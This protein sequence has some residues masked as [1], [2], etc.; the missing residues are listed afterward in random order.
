VVFTLPKSSNSSPNPRFSPPG[1]DHCFG[2]T[3]W[4]T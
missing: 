1:Y 3:G 2:N 4:S